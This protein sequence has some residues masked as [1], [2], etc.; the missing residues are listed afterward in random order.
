MGIT[1]YKACLW[2]LFKL[3]KKKRKTSCCLWCKIMKI[4]AGELN[5]WK[6]VPRCMYFTV[7]DNYIMS[8][9]STLRLWWKAVIFPQVECESRG[10][11]R[12]IK[13]LP[14]L[15]FIWIKHKVFKPI[16]LQTK[17][18]SLII[19]CYKYAGR[20]MLVEWNLIL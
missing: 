2:C 3:K 9:P 15:L 18:L 1:R 7:Y 17:L 19:T 8:F 6:C 5:F 11:E 4:F 10:R 16:K 20:K 13:T 14:R 12:G